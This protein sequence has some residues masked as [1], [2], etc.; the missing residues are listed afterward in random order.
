MNKRPKSEEP[1]GIADT[2][3]A[4]LVPFGWVPEKGFQWIDGAE[5]TRA[6]PDRFLKRMSREGTTNQPSEEAYLD[7]AHIDGT[8]EAALLKFANKHGSLG[9]L[10]SHFHSADTKRVW[11]ESLS[12]WQRHWEEFHRAF[13]LWEAAS[14]VDRHRAKELM[15]LPVQEPGDPR[16]FLPEVYSL[17]DERSFAR[18]PLSVAK[19]VVVLWINRNLMPQRNVST[20]E[21]RVPGCKELKFYNRLRVT[22][23]VQYTLEV[24]E[25]RRMVF[26]ELRVKPTSLLSA[27]WLQF[28]EYVAGSRKIRRCEACNQYMDVTDCAR[29]GAKRMHER[30]SHAAR[31]RRWRHANNQQKQGGGADVKT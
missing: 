22:P 8:D 7:F 31:V 15:T 13:D 19:K 11:G 23:W 12:A 6:L 29:P 28:A 4:L 21:C 16:P 14:E 10:L 25:S 2:R 3:S 5:G 1:L 30:C 18:D 24:R 20:R 17:T 9:T 26:V 27:I